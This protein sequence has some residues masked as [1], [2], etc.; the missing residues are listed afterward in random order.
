MINEI[1]S[2]HPQNKIGKPEEVAALVYALADGDFKFLHGACIDMSGGI[3]SRL[4][5]PE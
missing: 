3:S 1:A 2:F 5:D 4:H